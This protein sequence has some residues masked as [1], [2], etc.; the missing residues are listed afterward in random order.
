MFSFSGCG[1]LMSLSRSMCSAK[2]EFWSEVSMT[3]SAI[4]LLLE[5]LTSTPT[6]VSE[7]SKG[8]NTLFFDGSMLFHP[9]ILCSVYLNCR[10]F[11]L[12]FHPCLCLILLNRSSFESWDSLYVK[13]YLNGFDSLVSN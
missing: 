12:L 9:K 1:L 4:C 5:K 2:M 6:C 7:S 3:G 10:A 8:C 13:K 11:G